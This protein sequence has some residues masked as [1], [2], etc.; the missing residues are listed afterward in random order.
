MSEFTIIDRVLNMH[1]TMHSA[2]SLYK[3]MSTKMG[4]FGRKISVFNYF[5]KKLNLKSLRQL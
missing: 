3:L 1:P 5:C 4:R 2:K